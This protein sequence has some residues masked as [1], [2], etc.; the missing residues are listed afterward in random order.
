M[1]RFFGVR[2]WLC[3]NYGLQATVVVVKINGSFHGVLMCYLIQ[4]VCSWTYSFLLKFQYV[5]CII[6]YLR[7]CG[8][9]CHAIFLEA[10]NPRT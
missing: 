6:R 7:V 3:R 1:F 8:T 9:H 2:A 5:F 10:L 4:A